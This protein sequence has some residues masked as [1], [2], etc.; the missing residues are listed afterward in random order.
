MIDRFGVTKKS[1]ITTYDKTADLIKSGLT[2]KDIAKERDLTVETIITHLEKLKSLGK[3][4]SDIE[5]LKPAP[6][7]FKT[8]SLAFKQA[9]TDKLNPI[10][11]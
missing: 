5:Y 2:L 11:K 9:K 10:K 3:L 1:K 6:N 7:R 8:I 4:P